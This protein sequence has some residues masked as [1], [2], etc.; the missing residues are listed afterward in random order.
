MSKGKVE[1][2]ST[3]V[4]HKIHNI[5]QSKRNA[6]YR[7]RIYGLDQDRLD[8]IVQALS[9]ARTECDTEYDAVALENIC[10]HFL[11]TYEPD[12]TLLSRSRKSC[13]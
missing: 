10:L 3:S 8:T 5:T 7:L 12:S 9:I 1:V 4:V 11:A 13:N 2:R 6:L